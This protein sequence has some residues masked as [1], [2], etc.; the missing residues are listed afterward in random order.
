[1][2]VSMPGESLC[3]DLEQ[4]TLSAAQYWF[5]TGKTCPDITEKLLP[6]T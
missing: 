4:D 2:L 1:M 3:C 6:E 5:Q